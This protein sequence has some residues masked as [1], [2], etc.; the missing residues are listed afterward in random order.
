[1]EDVGLRDGNC[2]HNGAR[3]LRGGRGDCGGCV[4]GDGGGVGVGEVDD[5]V[6]L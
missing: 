6:F 3:G 4:F 5:F 2:D 1:M